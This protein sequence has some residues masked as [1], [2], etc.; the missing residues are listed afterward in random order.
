MALLIPLTP[1]QSEEALMDTDARLDRLDVLLEQQRALTV[2]LREI[3]E[4]LTLELSNHEVL[5]RL[6]R[7]ELTL[8]RHAVQADLARMD[9]TL[10][11]IHDL[12]ERGTDH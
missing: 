4:R 11:A 8:Q 2:A 9:T 6:T 7:R 3:T 5:M 12:L 1:T 10:T